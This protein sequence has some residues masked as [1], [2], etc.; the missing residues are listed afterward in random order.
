MCVMDSAAIPAQKLGYQGNGQCIDLQG[1]RRIF[2][3]ND[4]PKLAKGVISRLHRF[5]IVVIG[6]EGVEPYADLVQPGC[7][8]RPGNRGHQNIMRTGKLEMTF[9]IGRLQMQIPFLRGWGVAH[10]TVTVI[11]T[12]VAK[13]VPHGRHDK[14]LVERRIDRFHI[15]LFD[16]QHANAKTAPLAC[17]LPEGPVGRGIGRVEVEVIDCILYFIEHLQ[18]PQH[19][20]S[21][22]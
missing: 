5:E 4:L 21:S 11:H 15:V 14:E 7:E 9:R 13:I 3:L 12:K 17:F 10:P 19:L 16:Q 6:I 20:G 8:R 2:G 18:R 1:I 22:R